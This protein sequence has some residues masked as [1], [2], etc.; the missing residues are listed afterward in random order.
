MNLYKKL[1]IICGF[2]ALAVS[3]SQCF[4]DTVTWTPATERE[5]GTPLPLNEII[6]HN[7]Y[8]SDG[9]QGVYPNK[10]WIP[11]P[12]TE[13]IVPKG[14]GF[15][16]QAVVTTVDSENRESAFSTIVTITGSV[17]AD[18]FPPTNVEVVPDAI[19]TVDP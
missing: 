19:P 15:D 12:S 14:Q 6:G 13:S 16:R 8:F 2:I 17:I 4:A 11:M 1:I 7:V 10:T 18:P 9:T 3:V 5:D